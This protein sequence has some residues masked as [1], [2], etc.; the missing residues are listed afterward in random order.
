MRLSQSV[1][2]TLELDKNL[3]PYR[4]KLRGELGEHILLSLNPAENLEQLQQREA[5]LREW[6]DLTDHNGQFRFTAGLE[7]VTHMF[8]QARRSGILSG[9]ELL[10]VRAVL[11]CARHIREDL[12]ALSEGYEHVDELRRGIRDFTPELEALRVIEDSGRLSDNASPKLY[13]IKRTGRRLAQ[14]LLEDSDTANML[15]ERSLS[16]R[17]GRFLLLV[18]QEYINRFPGLAVERSASGNSVYMEPKALSRINNTLII[19]A[20]DEHNEE[21]SILLTLTRNILS[22][23]NAITN[24]E[25]VIGTLDLLCACDELIRNNHW[26]I[27]EIT[28]QKLFRLVGARHP[29]LREKA[30]PIDAECGESFT[31]LVINHRLKHWRQ[32]CNPQDCGSPRSVSVAWPASASTGRDSHR[33]V[34]RDFCGHRRR[35]EHRAEPIDVQR[36]PQEDYSHPEVFNKYITCA[37]GRVRRRDRS[38]RRRSVRRCDSP[39]SQ[40]QGQHYPRDDS[41]QPDKAI[42]FDDRR[43]RNR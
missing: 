3:L 1:T 28:P 21:R 20:Q 32:N 30:V 14:K 9:E 24:A 23:E 34:R 7:S 2:E 31:T 10:K 4:E 33:D 16:W 43:S 36:T 19:R 13:E 35:T 5:L 17:D 39:D 8:K 37:V 29:M 25:R 40:G 22:R 27:P 11:Q 12:A 18:R 26:V 6:L 38:S 15:Q 42:R 41:P